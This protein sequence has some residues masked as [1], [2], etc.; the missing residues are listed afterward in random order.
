MGVVGQMLTDDKT[1]VEF[2]DLT[3]LGELCGC[4]EKQV[5]FAEGML[6]GLSQTEAA[7]RAGYAGDRAG[8]QIRSTASSVA[9]AKPVQALLALAE[10]RGLGVPNAPG[11]REELL[12]ILWSHARSK[13]KQTSVRAAVE[14]DRIGKEEREGQAG[15]TQEAALGS[16][17]ARKYGAIMFSLIV[18]ETVEEIGPRFSLT[19]ALPWFKEVA[20]LLAQDFP[21]FWQRIRNGLDAD[22]RADADAMAA[23]PV[24]PLDQLVAKPNGKSNAADQP[25]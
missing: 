4:T 5:R 19:G 14:L 25:N 16:I 10:S 22:C 17:L 21:E 7:F 24:V 2:R 9:L 1:E 13:D 12:R 3:E 23:G 20:P 6:A 11:D 8:P 18:L 15:E